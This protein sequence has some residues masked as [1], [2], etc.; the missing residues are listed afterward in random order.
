MTK[1][2]VQNWHRNSSVSANDLTVRL[3]EHF[4]EICQWAAERELELALEVGYSI[5]GL[6]PL[7]IAIGNLVKELSHPESQIILAEWDAYPVAHE[8][9]KFVDAFS[10]DA[11]ISKKY[12]SIS[13]LGGV[14]KNRRWDQI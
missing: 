6:D 3:G 8:L 5:L 12:T 13:H 10:T 2:V 11:Y 1:D 9:K 4:A 14:N 7:T